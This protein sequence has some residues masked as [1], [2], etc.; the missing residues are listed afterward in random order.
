MLDFAAANKKD[1]KVY[2]ALV[3]FSLISF[4]FFIMG[5]LG[6]VLNVIRFL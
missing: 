6:I 5:S 2:V 3:T 1:G 4:T